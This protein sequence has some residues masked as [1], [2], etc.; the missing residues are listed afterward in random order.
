MKGGGIG[1]MIA[2][3]TD[4]FMSEEKILEHDLLS[5]INLFI[6]LF[7]HITFMVEIN[8]YS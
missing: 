8:L 5:H 6:K 7:N 1:E 4:R 3:F 2:A